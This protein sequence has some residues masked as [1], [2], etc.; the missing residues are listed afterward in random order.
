MQEDIRDQSNQTPR[1]TGMR[2]WRRGA[3]TVAVASVLSAGSGIMLARAN[4]ADTPPINPPA[5]QAPQK[6]FADLVQTVQPAVVS[7]VVEGHVSATEASG[8]QF[9][10]P[11][12][13]RFRD[14]FQHFFGQQMPQDGGDSPDV[15][16]RAAGSGFII[17]P[18]GYIVTNNH[19][20][21]GANDITVVLNDGTKLP[22]T[23]KGSDSKTDL[24]LLK[25][26][27]DKPLPWV[28]FGDSEKVRPG[29]WV[30]AI[31]NPF[32]L[33]GTV[34]T[35]I[36][37][38]RGR[39][40]HSGPYDD[41]L[42]ID[43]AINSGNSGGP[44]FDT[45]GNV[46][47]VNTAIYS[48]NGGNVGIGFA[49]PSAQAKTVVDALKQNGHVE[50]GYLGVQI[51]TVTKELAESL[52][53]PQDQGALVAAVTPDSPAAH[54]GIEVGDVIVGFNGK[55]IDEMR[56][57][58]RL[59]AATNPGEKASVKILR[60]GKSRQLQVTVAP[61]KEIVAQADS[62]PASDGAHLGVAVAALTDEARARFDIPKDVEGAVIVNVEP[63]SP[64]A[65]VGLRPG[66]VIRKADSHSIES[67][68]DLI[69]ALQKDAGK[70]HKQIVLLVNRAGSQWF[71][72][73]PLA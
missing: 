21:K 19:V 35:G 43:A 68:D 63:G 15:R 52:N 22:A 33:G 5:V 36:V 3:I 58:P 2:S 42:Q 41:Y 54:A 1:R 46:I 66:D 11:D 45:N 27:T 9:Q 64:A 39:D 32:G 65:R 44:L 10:F 56:E 29:D 31:G 24:A 62:G 70:K 73:V 69:G 18:A 60:D 17:D 67:P 13:E 6:S 34:T 20:T 61:Y 48:P 51:Q 25:V 30:V 37:S 8:P 57:L 59:V 28:K 50:R 26:D 16:V 14:F 71:V 7:I 55:S 23:L 12:D 4:V 47:G 53:L 38:A 40:I 49:I 72:P